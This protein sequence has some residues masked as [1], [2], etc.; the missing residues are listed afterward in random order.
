MYVYRQVLDGVTVKNL[1]LVANTADGGTKGTLLGT[2]DTCSTAFGKRYV[3]G[4]GTTECEA[5]LLI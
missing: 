5:V 4:P 1:E 3:S 2:L